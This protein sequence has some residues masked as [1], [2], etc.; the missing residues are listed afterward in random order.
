MEAFRTPTPT[1]YDP[2]LEVE[3][4]VT[5]AGQQCANV[6]YVALTEAARLAG[7]VEPDAPRDRV[8]I[9]AVTAESL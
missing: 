1:P 8:L 9:A 2:K 4:G 6:F 7:N 3:E 5:S